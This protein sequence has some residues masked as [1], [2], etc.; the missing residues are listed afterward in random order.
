MNKLRQLIF[1][2]LLNPQKVHYVKK[3]HEPVD[4]DSW[5]MRKTL[6]FLVLISND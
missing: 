6:G 4:A 5:N 3:I 2:S 1:S